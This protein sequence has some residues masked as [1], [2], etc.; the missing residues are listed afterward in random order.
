MK[1]SLE[2]GEFLVVSQ[3]PGK[4][5]RTAAVKGTELNL[6]LTHVE[7]LSFDLMGCVIY[8]KSWCD[9]TTALTTLSVR[10]KL[11]LLLGLSN[12]PSLTLG[13]LGRSGKKRRGRTPPWSKLHGDYGSLPF[14]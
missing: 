1:V 14:N 4:P 7:R 2:S 10:S 5:V 11:P 12:R 3:Q 13:M 8:L 6:E 9:L